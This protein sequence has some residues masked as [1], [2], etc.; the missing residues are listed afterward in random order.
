MKVLVGS[1]NPVKL[2]AVKEAFSKYFNEVEVLGIK[3][4]SKVSNQPINEETFQ[5]AKNRAMELVRIDQ[6]ERLGGEFFVGIEGGILKLFSRWF[7]FS[8]MCITDDKGKVGYGTSPFFELPENIAESLLSGTELGDVID[9]LS[10]EQNT[11]ERQGAVGYFTR[12][13]MDRK[14]IYIDGLV[15]ALVPFL[16]QRLYLK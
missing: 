14:R 9:Y 10:G 16:N 5:G 1:Q 7:D 13:V 15:A 11:K 3:V 6:E 12:G 4:N 2:E 8:A